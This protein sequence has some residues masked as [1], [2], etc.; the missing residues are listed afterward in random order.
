MAIRSYTS[1]IRSPHKMKNFCGKLYV[2][3]RSVQPC[4]NSRELQ[5]IRTRSVYVPI[6]PVQLLHEICEMGY[7][8]TAYE[9]LVQLRLV[10]HSCPN[11]AVLFTFLYV[12]LYVPVRSCTLQ[13]HKGLV[14][15]AWFPTP[16][17]M[18]PSCSRSYT[19]RYTFL[20]V[21]VRCGR[22]RLYM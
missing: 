6:H 2:L 4:R 18:W 11:V 14:R 20:C 5:E 7:G 1:R 17:L 8:P 10:S 19:G 16:V 21:P 3:I 9:R 12:P 13:S 15:C 22:T